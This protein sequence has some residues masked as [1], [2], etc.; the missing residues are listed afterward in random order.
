MAH[1]LNGHILSRLVSAL[2]ATR[3][4]TP[5]IT[6]TTVMPL[7]RTRSTVACANRA[8]SAALYKSAAACMRYRFASKCAVRPDR[9]KCA[10]R[11]AQRAALRRCHAKVWRQRRRPRKTLSASVDASD[12]STADYMTS[13]MECASN[14]SGSPHRRRAHGDSDF[15]DCVDLIGIASTHILNI[16]FTLPARHIVSD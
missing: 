16:L 11:R 14:P 10:A 6:A 12:E 2:C 3:Y 9:C 8:H 4:S 7:K 13:D 5:H 15:D 1:A